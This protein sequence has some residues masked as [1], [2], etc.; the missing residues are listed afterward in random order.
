MN[1][2]GLY[3]CICFDFYILDND[4][5]M[6]KGNINCKIFLL[7]WIFYIYNNNKINYIKIKK[8]LF[9]EYNIRNEFLVKY[10]Y[11]FF[12]ECDG[13]LYGKICE[14]VCNCG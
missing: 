2:D 9:L 7:F 3:N 1:V 13:F 8:I 12:L 6:C 4:G 11:Y 14:N 10:F 5:W